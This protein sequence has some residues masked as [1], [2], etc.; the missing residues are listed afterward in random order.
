MR[1]AKNATEHTAGRGRHYEQSRYTGGSN[2]KIGALPPAADDPHA[3]E[4]D[5]ELADPALRHRHARGVAAV[6]A[7]GGGNH[8]RPVATTGDPQM[9]TRGAEGPST[10]YAT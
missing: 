1:A 6:P 4:S 9:D 3:L 2:W 10:V 5:D 7:G 8:Q